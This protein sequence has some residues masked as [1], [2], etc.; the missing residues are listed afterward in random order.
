MGNCCA[1]EDNKNKETV[2]VEKRKKTQN[3]K[4]PKA[5]GA[6]IDDDAINNIFEEKGDIE[7]Q[8]WTDSSTMENDKQTD[9]FD[10]DSDEISL[11]RKGI[12]LPLFK[13]EVFTKV[14]GHMD[15]DVKA[16]MD[17]LGPFKYRKAEEP[18]PKTQLEVRPVTKCEDESHY[19]GQWNPD[20]NTRE[21]RGIAVTK[22]GSI[23]EGF[24]RDDKYNGA[25]RLIYAN[26]DLYQGQWKDDK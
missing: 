25:G 14:K 8:L 22:D 24:W 3:K 19:L 9:E 17:K 26:G 1:T 13:E 5:K 4:K 11:V 6:I 16:R 10:F 7:E 12:T 23:Y 2:E 18:K 21:G 20:N 15:K